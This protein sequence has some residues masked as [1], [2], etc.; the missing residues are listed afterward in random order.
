MP[1][2]SPN[3][4]L[5]YQRVDKPIAKRNLRMHENP[6]IK[7]LKSYRDGRISLQR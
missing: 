5:G 4:Y 6:S 2:V 7:R 1:A 3:V